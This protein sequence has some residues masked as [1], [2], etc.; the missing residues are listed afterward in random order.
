MSS[1]SIKQP[2]QPLM[3]DKD[4]TFRK[5][6]DSCCPT[7]C[8]PEGG[9]IPFIILA[10]SNVYSDIRIMNLDDTLY[11]EFSPLG[12]YQELDEDTGVFANYY[13]GYDLGLPKGSYY[14]M[15]SFGGI[16]YYSDTFRIIDSSLV[17]GTVPE[18][19][20]DA[21]HTPL[22]VFTNIIKQY[23]NRCD[24][25]C[26]VTPIGDRSSILP[27]IWEP[28]VS[29]NISSIITTLIRCDG[30]EQDISSD[31]EY[32]IANSNPFTTTYKTISSVAQQLKNTNYR[33]HSRNAVFQI[34]RIND[35]GQLLTIDFDYYFGGEAIDVTVKLIRGNNPM[36][37]PI[38]TKV[39]PDT[40][41]GGK[42]LTADFTAEGIFVTQGE[43]ITLRIER[44]DEC[45]GYVQAFYHKVYSGGNFG[46]V[47][48]FA[49]YKEDLSFVVTGAGDPSYQIYGI[50]TPG[51]D[52]CYATYQRA[53]ESGTMNNIYTANEAHTIKWDFS[54]IRVQADTNG[55]CDFYIILNGITIH[56]ESAIFDPVGGSHTFA[57]YT[58]TQ[59][60]S[61]G[62]VIEIALRINGGTGMAVTSGALCYHQ[63]INNTGLLTGVN[64]V[65][66]SLCFNVWV[67]KAIQV[68]SGTNYLYQTGRI[69]TQPIDCGIYYLKIQMG[70]STWYTDRFRVIDI[71]E[72]G[73]SE[74]ET[75]G[76]IEYVEGGNI[77]YVEGGDIEYVN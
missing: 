42:T 44:P 76:Y 75:H 2:P 74:D 34:I 33:F 17:L 32:I 25:E 67:K 37:V 73:Y 43:Y 50:F 45:F 18:I 57:A 20:Y 26:N 38:S 51:N 15:I 68:G 49:A 23:Y 52:I 5:D 59:A 13:W 39:I 11:G 24:D 7:I 14:L 9:F 8:I 22:R 53:D 21:F 40:A 27:F 71:A 64:Y 47:S 48:T 55:G 77:P 36:V 29:I 65:D 69:M 6:C 4:I 41:A 60:L 16:W 61:T 3:W 10:E 19:I 12:F 46:I 63:V 66:R 58:L 31:I 62:D 56:T 54:N 1:Q 30:E 72:I 35:T 28:Q 70:S